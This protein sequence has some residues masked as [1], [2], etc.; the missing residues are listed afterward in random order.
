MFQDSFDVIS[1]YPVIAIQRHVGD[2]GGALSHL[3]MAHIQPFALQVFTIHC[4]FSSLPVVLMMEV[5]IP[6]SAG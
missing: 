2:G 4:P 3:Q 5:F 6:I 1:M